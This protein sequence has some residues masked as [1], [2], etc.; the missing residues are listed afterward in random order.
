MLS[1]VDIRA[2]VTDID[3]RTLVYDALEGMLVHVREATR[4]IAEGTADELATEL[5]AI[6][7]MAD[8]TRATM[9]D[10]ATVQGGDI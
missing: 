8:A 3:R 6:A 5:Q 7:T 4:L 2:E 9:A 10:T 1:N